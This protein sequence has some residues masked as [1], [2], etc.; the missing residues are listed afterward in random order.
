MSC[1]IIRIA[2]VTKELHLTMI[3]PTNSLLEKTKDMDRDDDG[4]Y[5]GAIVLKPTPGIYLDTPVTVLDLVFI[6]V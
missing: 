2:T 3:S 4:G 1:A 5:E 6:P